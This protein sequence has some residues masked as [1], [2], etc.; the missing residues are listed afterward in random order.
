MHD[1][2]MREWPSIDMMVIFV[3]YSHRDRSL[4]CLLITLT[5]D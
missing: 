4:D 2:H 1:K 5:L 3:T